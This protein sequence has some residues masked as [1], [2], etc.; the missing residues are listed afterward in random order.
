[1]GGRGALLEGL[2]MEELKAIAASPLRGETTHRHLPDPNSSLVISVLG[3]FMQAVLSL[4]RRHAEN[5][6]VLARS[7]IALAV[8]LDREASLATAE[9]ET[10][11]DRAGPRTNA[12]WRS[13]A[14]EFYRFIYDL[15][16]EEG[17]VH[18]ERA[19][20]L[21]AAL[22]FEDKHNPDPALGLAVCAVRLGRTE[23]AYVFAME[24][25][26]RGG[27]HPRAFCIAGLCELEMGDRNAAQHHLAVATRLARARPEFREDM[28][29]AQ[30]LLLILNF[31]GPRRSAQVGRQPEVLGT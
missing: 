17:A 12:A 6:D 21:L 4:L 7:A 27:K 13:A 20:I 8:D 26:R 31:G 9:A 1:M 11:V 18:T 10:L 22:L 30:K 25:L 3:S 19:A 24:S 23:E 5:G 15:T 14:A 16:T 2:L 28:R 29:M